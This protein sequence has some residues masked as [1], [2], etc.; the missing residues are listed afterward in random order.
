MYSDNDWWSFLV[1]HGIKGQKWGVRNG[2]PYPI[3]P[4][5]HSS[6]EKKAMSNQAKSE[7]FV[8][9]AILFAPEILTITSFAVAMVASSVAESKAKKF[10]KKCEEEREAAPTDKKTGLKKQV[11]QK[12]REE[13]AKRV[14][15]EYLTN[16]NGAHNNCTNCTMAYE[17]RR[18]GYEVQAQLK[19]SGRNGV[20]FAKELFPKSKN[21]EVMMFPD[22]KKDEDGFLRYMN[23]YEQKAY[24]GSNKELSTKTISALKSE[25]AGSRGQLLI[26]WNRYGGHSVAYEITNDGKVNII[27]GQTGKVY[28]EKQSEAFLR[29]GVATQYQRLDNVDFDAKKIKKE[30]VR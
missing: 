8:E 20:K 21:K 2:P 9:L 12:T 30:A 25:P 29:N 4:G 22:P 11:E 3:S 26:T 6:S 17:L 15:P 18:R 27:D 1:H 23:T 14:N 24:N 19:S 16:P 13:D 28:N 7:G 10:Q 5:D